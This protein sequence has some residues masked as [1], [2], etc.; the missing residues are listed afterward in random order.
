MALHDETKIR[1]ICEHHQH[2]RYLWQL[3]AEQLFSCGEYDPY[4]VGHFAELGLQK[5]GIIGFTKTIAREGEKYNIIANSV[6]PS[7]GTNM[8]RTIRPENEVQMM[9]PEYVAPLVA[10]LCCEKPPITGQLFEAGTGWFAATRWQRT[11]GVDFDFEKG[12]PT[13]E[14]VAKVN[15]ACLKSKP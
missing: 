9:K 6:A 14:Q 8:T 12:V 13:L 4:R 10:A 7:A 15:L 3:W 11:R 5:C 2:K 1:Q